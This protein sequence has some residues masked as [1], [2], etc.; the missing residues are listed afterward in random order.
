MPGII[1]GAKDGKGRGRQVI[2][3]ARTCNLILIVLDAMK[4]LGHKRIIE[5]CCDFLTFSPF[6]FDIYMLYLH[7]ML[8]SNYLFY[9]A[10]V[11]FKTLFN[12]I[13]VA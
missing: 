1:E 10:S 11:L 12:F 8:F 9:S 2:S 6:V 13:F 7:F 5:V 4:P 3:V